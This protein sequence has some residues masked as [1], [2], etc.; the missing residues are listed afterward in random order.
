MMVAEQLRLSATA[1]QGCKF[2]SPRSATGDATADAPGNCPAQDGART[3]T[4]TASAPDGSA[5]WLQALPT[6]PLQPES[7]Q[8][9]P[10]EL[11]KSGQG[12]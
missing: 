9:F 5:R 2:S 3:K 1:T 8:G 12:V 10:N 7:A 6:L 4:A 11:D